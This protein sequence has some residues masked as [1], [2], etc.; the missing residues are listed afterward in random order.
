MAIK[1]MEM[2]NGLLNAGPNSVCSESSIL[3]LFAINQTL[4]DSMVL[5][6]VNQPNNAWNVITG[7]LTYN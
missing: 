3:E 2:M 7:R 5:D 1:C 6:A 4:T